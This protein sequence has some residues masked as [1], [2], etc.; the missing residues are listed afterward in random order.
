MQALNLQPATATA[1]GIPIPNLPTPT[2]DPNTETSTLQIPFGEFSI[3]EALKNGKVK[4]ISAILTLTL[5]YRSNW[6]T[7]R[8][9]RTSTRQL[10]K[11]IG[12]SQR[13]V[14]N[15]LKN[16]ETWITR[17]TQPNGNTPGTWKVTHHLCNP[18]ETPTDKDGN[19]QTFAIPRG[20]NGPFERMFKGEITWKA[21]LLWILLKRNTDWSKRDGIT[22]PVNM[23]TLAKWTGF[24]TAT[25][26]KTIAELQ[27]AG[28]LE[29]LTE[30]WQR[31]IFQL[32]PKPKQQPQTQRR[33]KKKQ[34]RE[35]RTNGDWKISFNERY[36]VNIKTAEIQTRSAHNK[37][38][39]KKVSDYH[40][41]EIMPKPIKKAF[42]KTIQ[43]YQQWRL[44]R[45][46][47]GFDSIVR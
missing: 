24:S 14:R 34:Q 17:Q 39:W 3:L 32:Y 30:K 22:H 9:W 6:T 40:F 4:P 1:A 25:I 10:A 35:M 8:T 27:D 36:R 41:G 16:A 31:S 18:D 5:G 44:W 12:T 13:Y 43:E 45:Q 47:H 33:R 26:A 15:T 20:E 2:Q 23:K 7:G 38:L 42:N 21:C 46:K 29:R 11:L 37:G 28:M 19:P